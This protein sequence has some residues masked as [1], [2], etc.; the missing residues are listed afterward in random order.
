MAAMVM[1]ERSVAGATIAGASFPAT[2]TAPANTV[3]VPRCTIK[4]EKCKDG[5]KLICC[6]EDD[7]A[8]ATLQNLCKSLCDGLCSVSCLKN[9]LCVCQCN[10]ALCNCTCECTADG[11]CITCCSGDKA[12]CQQIQA[13]CDC[14]AQ[15]LEAGCTCC[16]CFAG[17]PVCCGTC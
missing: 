16:V 1:M 17:T 4:V 14:I 6:C 5:A 8:C 10:F 7:L 15:C 11:V 2:P 9:G 13:C 3:V 12:C